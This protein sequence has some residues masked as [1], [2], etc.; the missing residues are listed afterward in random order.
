MERFFTP[1]CLLGLLSACTTSTPNPMPSHPQVDSGS[2]RAQ[3]S[4]GIAEESHPAELRY[5]RYTLV[6][7]EPTTEQRDL[8]AQIIDVSIPSSLNPSVQDALQYVLQRSGYS[9]C[10]AT[11]SVKVLF[12]RPLPAAHYRLGPIPL[13]RTLQVL[14]GPAWQLTTD[15]VSRSVCFE[16]LKTNAGV[17]LITPVLPNRSEARP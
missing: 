5:G 4:K 2:N 13:H 15:E 8:L 11:A 16:Q 7:T 9:L 6:S 17:V 12:T 14:A 1:V 3:H 10:P